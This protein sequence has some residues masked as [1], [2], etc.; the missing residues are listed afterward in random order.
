MTS[1]AVHESSPSASATAAIK[2]WEDDPMGSVPE[3]PPPANQPV[4]AA[5][6]DLDPAGLNVGIAG[7]KPAPDIYAPGTSEFRYWVLADALARA[8]R[9]GASEFPRAPRGNP[10]TVPAS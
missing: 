2:S 3:N 4:Q 1:T 9:S 6:P 7:P 10:T 8:A 5:Q